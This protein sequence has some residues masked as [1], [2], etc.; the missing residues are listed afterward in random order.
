MP[1]SYI[2][3]LLVGTTMYSALSLPRG[4]LM[5][6]WE[7]IR[8]FLLSFVFSRATKTVRIRGDSSNRGGSRK[9]SLI[10]CYLDPESCPVSCYL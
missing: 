1:L 10:S 8:H 5:T 4:R 3:C 6:Q 2:F 9:L 7:P